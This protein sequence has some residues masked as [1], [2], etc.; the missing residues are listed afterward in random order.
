M[1]SSQL[2]SFVT[3]LLTA[4]GAKVTRRGAH[5]LE[6]APTESLSQKLGPNG[7]SLAFNQTGLREDPRSELAT[8]G[9]PVFDR[10]LDL[11]LEA[12]RV[13][14]QFQP[15]PAR[16]RKAPD[17]AKHI[18]LARSGLRIGKPAAV[19]TPRYFHLYKIQYSLE[20]AHDE[21]ETVCIDGIDRKALPQTPDLGELW[22]TLSPEP[23]EQRKVQAAFPVPREIVAA[24]LETLERRLRK[25]LGRL[26][27][28]SD[29]N[30]A[31]E[32]ESIRNYFQQLIEETKTAGRRWGGAPQAKEEKIRVLQLDWKRRIEEAQQFWSPRVE[33]RL[34]AVAVIQRPR[35]AFP[36][37]RASG[38]GRR[39][40]EGRVFYDELEGGFLLPFGMKGA[41][42]VS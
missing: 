2:R 10:I 6:I 12:G 18:R 22:A 5:L 21:L 33:I 24:S 14:E 16:A 13:G 26:R 15:A 31:A 38:K 25:R 36:I 39:K 20:E 32:T 37:E 40:Q 41:S 29:Q 9:N 30:L 1:K 27:N 35:L 7:L 11:A 3:E 17:P 4:H 42:L 34:A 28:V 8:V 19:Y 23:D